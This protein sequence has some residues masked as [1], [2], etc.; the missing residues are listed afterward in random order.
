VH[1]RAKWRGAQSQ[2]LLDLFELIPVGTRSSMWYGTQ[3]ILLDGLG[4]YRLVHGRA[5]WSSGV[6]IILL[7]VLS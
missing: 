6:Q 7:D 3:R 5:K 2:T 1:G 4:W